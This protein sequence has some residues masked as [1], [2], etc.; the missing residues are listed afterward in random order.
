MDL[1]PEELQAIGGHHGM[2]REGFT[3]DEI[4]IYK[5][6]YHLAGDFWNALF[7]LIAR[8]D[9]SNY[10]RLKAGFPATV[11]AF[12]KYRDIEGWFQALE[13]KLWEHKKLDKRP[14]MEDIPL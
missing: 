12:E 13:Y 4:I 1:K 14:E 7:K 2:L 8:A 5:W 6:Q 10:D 11:G 9:E 3:P